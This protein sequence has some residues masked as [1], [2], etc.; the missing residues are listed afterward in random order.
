[1]NQWFVAAQFPAISNPCQQNKSLLALIEV[2][3]CVPAGHKSC[4]MVTGSTHLLF[5][6][7]SQTLSDAEYTHRCDYLVRKWRVTVS[8]S[9]TRNRN[10]TSKHNVRTLSPHADINAFLHLPDKLSCSILRNAPHATVS[11]LPNIWRLIA[12]VIF[13][14][15]KQ[16]SSRCGFLVTMVTWFYKH[17]AMK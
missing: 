6:I 11:S 12:D 9:E 1:M 10:E 5:F 8:Q 7:K 16:K 4:T 17:K 3:Q 14:E 2:K 15:C 13:L